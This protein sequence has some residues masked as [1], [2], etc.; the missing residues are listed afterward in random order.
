MAQLLHGC[1]ANC[2]ISN[3]DISDLKG[4][5]LDFGC[6]HGSSPS[7]CRKMQENKADGIFNLAKIWLLWLATADHNLEP[8]FKVMFHL[9]I[10]YTL[11]KIDQVNFPCLCSFQLKVEKL[12]G[13]FIKF[14]PQNR[15]LCTV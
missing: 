4:R 14:Y 15:K 7:N 5:V 3:R 13:S 1:V 8:Y 9:M 10:K 12:L 6:C 2:C 11:N